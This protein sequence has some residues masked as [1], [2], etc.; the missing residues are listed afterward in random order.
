MRWY[1]FYANEGINLHKDATD[2]VSG[3]FDRRFT[4]RSVPIFIYFLARGLSLERI[5]GAILGRLKN[6][7]CALLYSLAQGLSGDG[8]GSVDGR[9]ALAVEPGRIEDVDAFA[10]DAIEIIARCGCRGGI[11]VGLRSRI[12]GIE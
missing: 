4:A 7:C 10:A 3:L 6:S 2:V 1:H 11:G 5:W 8:S 9:S 12:V